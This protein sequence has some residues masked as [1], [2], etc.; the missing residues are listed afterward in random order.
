MQHIVIADGSR[1]VRTQLRQ[2]LTAAGFSVSEAADGE[3]ALERICAERPSLTIVDVNMPSLDGYG[4]CQRLRELGHP[5]DELPIIFL[6]SVHSHAVEVLGGQMG[7]S[8][9]KPLDDQQV[10]DAVRSLVP[11]SV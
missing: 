2:A 7:A 8:L 4:V 5:F 10:L 3:Q 1:T 6:T 9:T 11:L